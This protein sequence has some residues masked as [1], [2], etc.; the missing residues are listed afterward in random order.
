MHCPALTHAPLLLP[1]KHTMRCPVSSNVSAMQCPVLTHASCYAMSGTEMRY[2]ATR[3]G[4]ESP[5]CRPHVSAP[6]NVL[7]LLILDPRP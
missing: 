1:C 7:L 5:A 3:H 4:Q 6:G 2:A